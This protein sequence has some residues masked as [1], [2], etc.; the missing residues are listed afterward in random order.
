MNEKQKQALTVGL[1]FSVLLAFIVGYWYFMNVRDTVEKSRAEQTKIAAEIKSQK[2][3]LN[4]IEVFMAN[5]DELEEMLLRV[6]KAKHRLPDDPEAIEFLAILTD[7]LNKT[8]VS[9]IEVS[10]RN[11]IPRA[12]YVE[13]PYFIKGSARYHEFGQLLNL[14]ECNPERFMRVSTFKMFK[15]D[16]RPSIHPI[17]VQIATFMFKESI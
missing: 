12:L 5:K 8:G 7:S 1:I 13:I 17:E 2:A 6:E 10:P 9:V 11:H 14:I 4:E 3:R 15:N 16:K